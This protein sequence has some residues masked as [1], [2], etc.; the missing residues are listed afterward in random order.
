VD[1]AA[2]AIET[3]AASIEAVAD[4]ASGEAAAASGEASGEAVAECEAVE[5]AEAVAA[6]RNLQMHTAC[7]N[8]Y[9][10]H[11]NPG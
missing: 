4:D 11:C 2:G 3:E 9:R 10:N 7:S 1:N 5:A 6:D 8:S